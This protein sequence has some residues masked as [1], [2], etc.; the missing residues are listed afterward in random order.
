MSLGTA[1]GKTWRATIKSAHVAG[2][3]ACGVLFIL[4]WIWGVGYGIFQ[5]SQFQEERAF[6]WFSLAAIL[7]AA[8]MMLVI[9]GS[10]VR[11]G[12]DKE[13][14]E[15]AAYPAWRTAAWL[16]TSGMLAWFG[17]HACELYERVAPVPS[18]LDR[19][20]DV[21]YLI[22]PAPTGVA[23][24]QLFAPGLKRA[25]SRRAEM[26]SLEPSAPGHSGRN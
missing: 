26:T 25:L 11:A 7:T 15:S 19:C 13:R 5:F 12:G 4:P 18:W 21:A 14:L 20:S 8:G 16:F 24:H 9:A 3:G 17:Q 22:A 2:K 1:A 10:V 6:A 23:A